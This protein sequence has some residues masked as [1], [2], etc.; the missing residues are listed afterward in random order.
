MKKIIAVTL[1]ALS[2]T[3]CGLGE[4]MPYALASVQATLEERC[5]NYGGVMHAYISTFENNSNVDYTINYSCQKDHSGKIR[6]T[7]AKR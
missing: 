7:E 2:L 5:S 3:A 6:L 4:R 1:L